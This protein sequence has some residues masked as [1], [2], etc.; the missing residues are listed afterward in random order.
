MI[1]K[2]LTIKN[3]RSYCGE[4]TF[5]FTD[6]LTL[7]IGG[8]GDGKTTF[9]DALDWL[10]KSE[11]QDMNKSYISE[12]RKS[13]LNYGESDE[14]SVSLSFE[15]NGEKSLTKKFMFVKDEDNNVKVKDFQFQGLY[16]DSAERR[17]I[18]GGDLLEQCF[19][20]VIRKYCLF[21]GEENLDVFRNETALKTLVDKFSDIS[22]FDDFVDLSEEFEKKSDSA[23]KKELSKDK[24]ISKQVNELNFSL[25]KI[26]REIIN[27]EDDK[28]KQEKEY[29]LLISKINVLE[30]SQETSERYHEIK[31]RINNL[32][33]K[34][35]NVRRKVNIKSYN[36]QLLDEVWIL[37]AFPNIFK[38][39]ETKMSNFSKL[40]RKEEKQYI[41]EKAKA[42]GKK[43][44]LKELETLS[45]GT[46]SLPWY[47]P[48]KET[49]QEMLDDQICKVCGR[50]F[51]KDSKPYLFLKEKL[52]KFI[53]LTD[54]SVNYKSSQETEEEDNLFQF[55]YIEELHSL[56]LSLG[57]NNAKEICGIK[58]E[59]INTIEFINKRKEECL[60]IEEKIKEVEAEKQRLLIQNNNLT[61]DLLDKNFADI[62]GFFESKMNTES[63]I[64][65]YENRLS[66]L[67]VEKANLEQK[68]KAL[69]PDEGMINVYSKV[70]IVFNK[71]LHAFKNAKQSNLRNF[72]INLEQKANAYLKKLN[73]DDFHGIIKIIETAND[74]ASIAL[75]SSNGTYIT[76]PNGALKTTMYMSVLFAISDLTTRKREIDYP[77]IFDAPTSSF[78]AFKEDEFYNVIDKINKQCIIVTKD[79]LDKDPITGER[80]LNES[81][82]ASLSC[83]IY[84]I[85]KQE[86]YNP[87]DL[88]TIRTNLKKIK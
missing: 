57:G 74:S 76:A 46:Q 48:D 43:E 78:E 45:N 38:E 24:K 5:N 69:T 53:E 83:S 31:E 23:Y 56:G 44:T 32:N 6:G 20:T 34:L 87:S 66:E 14:V 36:L 68:Y 61:E 27:T 49:M 62:K 54:T 21:K 3:F 9:F 4:N 42:Q 67:K 28:K 47:V 88:S 52:Q 85:E 81:K 80:A 55:N 77:L 12:M 8:N 17:I 63:K 30:E 16:E 70:H 84:R 1:L 18:N 33:N 82:I 79:L 11:L 13:Q 10:F 2:Q 58:N 26:N 19:D 75:V 41:K 29:N 60:E 72:L 15:H 71:I 39:Y 50:P 40:K 64:S 37:C 51:E 25:K 86:G 73:I 65:K 59:I 22:K 35:H 7:I